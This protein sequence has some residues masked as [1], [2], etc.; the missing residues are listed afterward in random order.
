MCLDLIKPVFYV[1]ERLL[2]RAVVHEDDTHGPFVICLCNG[3]KPLL[4]SRVPH[5]Q[6][7]SLILHRYGVDYEVNSCRFSTSD[8]TYLLSACGLWGNGPQKNEVECS[9][10]QQTSHR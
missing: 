2:F 5:L 7:Y 4:T 3:S 9:S 1:V 10:S 8:N 6:L